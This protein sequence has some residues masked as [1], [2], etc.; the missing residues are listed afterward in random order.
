MVCA[1]R[2]LFLIVFVAKQIEVSSSVTASRPFF[3]RDLVKF[4][5][6][7]RD[8]VTG[9]IPH[10]SQNTND[11]DDFCTPSFLK[12]YIRY[13]IG[14]C[15]K[16]RIRVS[17]VNSKEFCAVYINLTAIMMREIYD[18]APGRDAKAFRDLPI[19]A[20]YDGISDAHG[21]YG[22]D[23]QAVFVDDV[24]LIENRQEIVV[25]GGVMIWL[26]LLDEIEG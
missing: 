2:K 13:Y 8:K 19:S 6:E 20:D 11:W 21:L 23:Q 7:A 16:G 1:R 25:R 3:E 5:E 4:A 22:D 14:I 12:S 18:H 15:L 10:A 9:C 26:R 17:E 24:K